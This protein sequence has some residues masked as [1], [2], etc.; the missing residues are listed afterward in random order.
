MKQREVEALVEELKKEIKLMKRLESHPNIV[1]VIG[2]TFKECKPILIVELA[3]STLDYYLE[4]KLRVEAVPV[5]WVEKARLCLDVLVGLKGLH[6]VG[7]VHGDLKGENIL[8]FVKFPAR[9]PTAKISDFGFSST[10]TSSQS[11][12]YLLFSHHYLCF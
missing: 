4:D 2:V 11:D 9:I 1:Q 10:F 12:C 6:N 7:V 8:V 3:D 5:G